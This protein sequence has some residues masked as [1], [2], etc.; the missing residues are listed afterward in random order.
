MAAIS[1]EWLKAGDIS[2]LE[3][4]AFRLQAART[5]ENAVLSARDTKL[6][7]DRLAALLGLEDS[8]VEL[9]IGPKPNDLQLEISDL[10]EAAFVGRSDLR[11]AEIAIESAGQKVG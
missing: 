2:G 6:A 4:T 11:A 7:E 8:L 1:A 3:E 5:Q 9:S 10:L